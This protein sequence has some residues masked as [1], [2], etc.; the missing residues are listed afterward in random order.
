MEDFRR[1][2]ENKEVGDELEPII[3]LE[4]VNVFL[5]KLHLILL[6]YLFHKHGDE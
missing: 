3:E 1:V 6:V 5:D 2:G 4:H